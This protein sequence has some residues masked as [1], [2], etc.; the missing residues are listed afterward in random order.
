MV[1]RLVWLVLF[2][3][4]YWWSNEINIIFEFGYSAKERFIIFLFTEILNWVT[5]DTMYFLVAYALFEVFMEIACWFVFLI[6]EQKF[7][8]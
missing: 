4:V 5:R 3:N 1:T 2:V 6:V 8:F 7:L